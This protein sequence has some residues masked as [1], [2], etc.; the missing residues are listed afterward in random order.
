MRL[1]T[2]TKEARVL[3]LALA[4]LVSMGTGNNGESVVAQALLGRIADCLRLQTSQYPT[5]KHKPM[6]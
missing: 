5:G 4:L 2:S 3:Q 6:R 1:F